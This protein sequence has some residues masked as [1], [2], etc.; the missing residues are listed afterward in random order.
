VEGASKVALSLLTLFPGRAGGAETYVRGLL[1]GLREIGFADLT[2]LGNRHIG[3]DYAGWPVRVQPRYRTGDSD[4]TRFVAMNAGRIWPR[5][6]G[7][8]FDVVHYPVTV[9]VPRIAGAPRVVSLLDVQHHELPD[10]FSR[11]ERWLRGWAYDDAARGA[12]RVLTISEHARRTIVERLGIAPERVEAI[13][14]GVDH[15][16]FTPD[17]PRRD[18]LGDYVLYPAN[19]WPHKN[20][21]R[22]LAAW[23]SVDPALTLVLTGQAMG[24]SFAADRVTHLGHVPQADLPALYRGARAVVFPSLFEGFGL[25]PLEAMACGT[26]VAASDA[27]SIA[28]VCGDAALLFDPHDPGAIADAIGRVASDEPLRERLRTAGTAR[29]AGFTWSEAARRHLATYASVAEP[30]RSPGPASTPS[31]NAGSTAS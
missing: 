28:E 23:R 17:G 27:G 20:H 12:D 16:R 4:A 5:L 18:D 25:P 1:A 21:D 13:H 15:A 9:P 7:R 11:A 3:S 24:R 2:V 26:P 14:L 10:M 29:A 6:D 30:S 22:L 19:A 8:P 31:A